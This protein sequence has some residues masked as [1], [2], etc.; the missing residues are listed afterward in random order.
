MHKSTSVFHGVSKELWPR[1]YRKKSSPES[2][3]LSFT[4]WHCTTNS[5]WR[6][7]DYAIKKCHYNVGF[8][9]K[10]LNPGK[11][12]I[13]MSSLGGTATA[14]GGGRLC[15][16]PCISTEGPPGEAITMRDNSGWTISVQ[17]YGDPTELQK[18]RRLLCRSTSAAYKN[19]KKKMHIISHF[20]FAP[21]IAW[22]AALPP[23]GAP[24]CQQAVGAAGWRASRPQTGPQGHSKAPWHGT[25]SCPDC[26]DKQMFTLSPLNSELPINVHIWETTLPS[27]WPLPCPRGRTH[28]HLMC[29]RELGAALWG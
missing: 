26:V 11:K 29:L 27:I 24:P 12:H 17:I 5:L 22:E 18:W 4:L 20:N 25:G 1:A 9:R 14:E 10:T 6:L 8:K 7:S 21:E 23:L 19:K 3:L 15:N 2:L 16:G 13:R 28:T